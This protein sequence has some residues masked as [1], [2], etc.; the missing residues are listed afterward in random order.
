M[1]SPDLHP[2]L[3]RAFQL[4]LPAWFRRHRRALPWR[5]RRT[6]YRVWLAELM[7]QQTRV[8]QARDYFL[9]FMRRFPTLTAL[10]AAD[11]QAV[12]K[13]WEGLGYYS[14]ARRAHRTAQWLVQQGGGKF[15][16]TYAGLLALPGVG[17]YTA[18]AVG[19]LAFNLDV[20]VVDG[21]VARVLCR[22]F[23]CAADPRTGAGQ[24]QLQAWADGLL[25]RGRAGEFNEALMELG[26]LCCTPRQPDCPKCPLRKNCRA[27]ATG[28]PE[29]YPTKAAKKK[30]P[31]KIVGAAVVVNRRG[32]FLIA[33][34]PEHA[35]LGGL[36]EFPGG[37]QEPGE[38]MEQCLARELREEMGLRVRV[39]P[40][41]TVAR[42][43]YSHFTIA[44]HA[45]W[46]R[47]RSGRPRNIQCQAHA[48]VPLS[49]FGHYPFSRA[50]HYIIAALRLRRLPPEF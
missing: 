29:A 46:C 15:P 5:T 48:W 40:R 4:G 14:R 43:A 31:H 21:N 47:I 8:D 24:R 27:Y 18:A 25:P 20:A 34:R 11:Q 17:P 38:T 49:R 45:H 19:S 23:A 13:L 6:P 1:P 39:G 10:A 9:R 26:A 28:Q 32:E 41:L 22:V 12:L 2:N 37:K 42:H 7:L 33:Q 44:L 3:R 16:T 30:P 35:M 50:D 36:W